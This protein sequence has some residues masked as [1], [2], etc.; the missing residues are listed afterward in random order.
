MSLPKD[1]EVELALRYLASTDESFARLT[2]AVKALEHKAKVIRSQQYLSA[3]GTVAERE[4]KALASQEY[5]DF[6]ESYENIMADREIE[7]AKRKRAELTID[8]WRSAGANR[9]SGQI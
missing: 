3:S 8:V 2:A 1:G 7:A 9:R 6:V 5:Q 4:A